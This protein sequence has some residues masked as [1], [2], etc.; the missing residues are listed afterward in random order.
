MDEGRVSEGRW[1]MLKEVAE[2]GIENE[3][4]GG[5]RGDQG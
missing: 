2:V 1:M 4:V 5:N 3:R